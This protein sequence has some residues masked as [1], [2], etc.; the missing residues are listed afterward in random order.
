MWIYE[1]L[2]ETICDCW[3]EMN[4]RLVG[5]VHKNRVDWSRAFYTM[6]YREI[7]SCKLNVGSLRSSLSLTLLAAAQCAV[8]RYFQ[9]AY[10]IICIDATTTTT[11][12]IHS[13]QL[14]HSSTEFSFGGVYYTRF[15]ALLFCTLVSTLFAAIRC[16]CAAMW[17]NLARLVIGWLQ[18]YFN[19]NLE[20]T[21]QEWGF[22][23]CKWFVI[24]LFRVYVY[25]VRWMCL[26]GS[27]FADNT[28]CEF[29][30]QLV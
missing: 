10:E 14:Q 17:I 24:G 15:F 7:A 11:T 4:M 23:I 22:R 29:H 21:G 26:V 30:V 13:T 5:F 25:A 9:S 19:R 12:E 2:E 1:Y 20:N 16:V 8:H 28:K 27:Q 6:F 18:V 3:M